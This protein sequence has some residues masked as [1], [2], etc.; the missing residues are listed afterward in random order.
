[1]DQGI[2]SSFEQAIS[3]IFK[4]YDISVDSISAVIDNHDKLQVVSMVGITGNL[5]GN[6]ILGCSYA[7]AQAIVDFLFQAN[8][9]TPLDK[10]FGDI[11]RATI[12]E[13]T[14]QIAGRA[15][16]N[17]SKLSIDCN[18]TPP[19]ILTGDWVVP[20]F[21]SPEEEYLASVKGGFGSAILRIGIKSK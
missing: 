10:G 4:E 16:M 11:Q 18:M 21:C 17:L 20:D 1:V 7:S 15:L 6:I 9:L 13:F 8:D 2:N 3:E 5:K 12:G 14:N 19:T